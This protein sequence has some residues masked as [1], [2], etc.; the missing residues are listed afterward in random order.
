M[1]GPVKEG[2]GW[3]KR[4]KEEVYNLLDDM[5][6]IIKIKIGELRGAYQ[7]VKLPPVTLRCV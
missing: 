2:G 5:I 1:H 3:R 6:I 4:T 7:V